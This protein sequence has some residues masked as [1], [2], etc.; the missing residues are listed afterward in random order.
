MSDR[1]IMDAKRSTINTSVPVNDPKV[2]KEVNKIV[3]Q[4]GGP[5]LVIPTLIGLLG[6][7]FEYGIK[8]LMKAGLINLAPGVGI[9]LYGISY[10]AIFISSVHALDKIIG[11]K[12]LGHH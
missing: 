9:L 11:G 2:E 4:F 3:S 12:I 1:E 10:V 5:E 7:A 6:I 8:T